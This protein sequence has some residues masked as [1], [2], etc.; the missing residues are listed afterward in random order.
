MSVVATKAPAENKD[1]ALDWSADLGTDTIASS[2]F[3]I[4]PTGGTSVTQTGNTNTQT[5]VWITGGVAGT[6]YDVTNTVT[7]TAGRV[8]TKTFKLQ[9]VAANY[10]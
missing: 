1:Y 8:L 7:T 10:L 4:S 6:F 2:Q 5:T 3:S 9:V